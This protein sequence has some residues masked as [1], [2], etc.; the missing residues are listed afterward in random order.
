MS[1]Q[2]T[3]WVGSYP[4]LE[5]QSVYST[6]AADWASQICVC[7]CVCVRACVNC[8]CLHVFLNVVY[9]YLYMCW[10]VYLLV[11]MCVSW[12]FACV[13]CVCMCVLR[14]FPCE[15]VGVGSC[16]VLRVVSAFFMYYFVY[17]CC[18]CWQT[19]CFECVCMCVYV[20]VC[21]CV[22]VWVFM[23]AFEFLC[24]DCLF[25]SI[26][27]HLK[28]YTINLPMGNKRFTPKPLHNFHFVDSLITHE[29]VYIYIMGR[30]FA[31]GLRINLRSSHT[32]NSKNPTW[33]RLA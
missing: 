9:M 2:D 5:V 3:R 6:P 16:E 21:V 18:V 27:I 31:N 14:V 17:R 1:Y 20:C 11:H 7:V 12:I 13:R 4:S 28:Q 25:Q 8:A 30:V 29:I 10:C 23:Y 33:C 15:F 32:K 22:C 24:V 19:L 26:H